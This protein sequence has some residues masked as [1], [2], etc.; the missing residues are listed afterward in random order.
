MLSARYSKVKCHSC[1]I[2]SNY[3]LKLKSVHVSYE[4]QN[5]D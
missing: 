5:S 4:L 1:D 2:A 3:N